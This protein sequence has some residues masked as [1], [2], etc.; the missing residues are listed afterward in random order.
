MDNN[1]FKVIIQTILDKSGVKTGLTDVQDFLNK[2]IVKI[3]PQIDSLSLKN[4][5]KTVSKELASALN[6]QFGSSLTGNDVFKIL[7]QQMKQASNSAKHLASDLQRVTATNT[8]QT[9][10]SNNTKAMKVWG[11]EINNIITKLSSIDDLT[12]DDFDNLKKQFK[13]IQSQAR[14]TGNLGL[15]PAGKLT[16]AWDKFG[17]WSLATGSLMGFVHKTKEAV[18]ELKQVD[19]LLTEI[20]KT[21][22]D[23][24]KT[25]L[26]LLGNDS[27]DE[28]SKYGR[29]STD[30]LYSVQEMSRAGYNNRKE[31]SELSLLA[32]SA[33]D[34]TSE[35]ANDY[36]IASDAAYGYQGNVE[37]L[38]SLLDSQNQVT[39]RNAVS[40]ED[41][42][43]ATKKAANQ[44]SNS[45]IGEKEMTALL[46]TGIATSREKGEVVGRA[47]KG[48][49]MNL[50]QVKNTDEGEET[51]EEDLAKVE[52]RLKSLNIQMKYTEDGILRLRNPI[53]ILKDLA[54][55]YNSL[56]KDSAD[57][58]GIIA[59]IGGKYR[60]NVLSSILSNWDK[61]EKMLGDYENAGGSAFNEAMKSAN[62]MEGSL[63]RLSNT[64]TDTVS[65]I[66]NSDGIIVGINALNGLLSIVNDVTGALG[67][68]GSIG[69][70][71][72]IALNKMLG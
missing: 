7:N 13:Q 34:L 30:Y 59:D 5:L 61:Y 28:A 40:M 21:A 37:K 36:L 23:L 29:K 58:A 46:G 31:M 63:N 14:A 69:A 18:T 33:G 10:A 72:G 11:N 2:N 20:S 16:K 45:N 47:V 54:D 1:D 35:L 15:S 51:S 17:G 50:Q 68:L 42:A 27:F 71:G 55:T 53:D 49:I 62:N 19:T 41:L 66:A 56:P 52:A 43:E 44:L 26:K 39:N 8:I 38:T 6:S 60:G 48:I 24:S 9:W 12:R 3:T 64:W 65:N 57:R 22:E 67:S 70:I 4:N 25:D 32:Q